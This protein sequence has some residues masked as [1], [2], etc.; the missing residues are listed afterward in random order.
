MNAEP[1]TDCTACLNERR[2]RRVTYRSSAADLD[3]QAAVV[4]CT[5]LFD[6]V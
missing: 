6:A 4:A 5:P 2:V 3:Q 1:S